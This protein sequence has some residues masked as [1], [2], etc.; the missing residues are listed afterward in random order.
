[1]SDA[2]RVQRLELDLLVA[3]NRVRALEEEVLVLRSRLGDRGA[4]TPRERAR[5]SASWRPG[6]P[7]PEGAVMLEVGDE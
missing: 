5:Y 3:Q 2:V 4:T 6:Q 1:M 7:V